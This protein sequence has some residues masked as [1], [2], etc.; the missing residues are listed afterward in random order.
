MALALQADGSLATCGEADYL[1]DMVLASS[2]CGLTVHKPAHEALQH[3]QLLQK[4]L[5]AQCA[6]PRLLASMLLFLHSQR[7]LVPGSCSAQGSCQALPAQGLSPCS[8]VVPGAASHTDAQ[9]MVLQQS[10]WLL[11]SLA[12]VHLRMSRP[13]TDLVPLDA[14]VDLKLLVKVLSIC[15]HKLAEFKAPLNVG[16]VYEV[17]HVEDLHPLI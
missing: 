8:F 9:Y 2:A 5:S 7:C 4:G 3:G 1:D 16:C 14:I 15:A 17:V 13:M 10:D 11:I 12:L 6:H